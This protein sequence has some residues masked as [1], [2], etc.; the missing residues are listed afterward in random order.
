MGKPTLMLLSKKLAVR[1]AAAICESL[2][3]IESPVISL[4][5]ICL[6]LRFI[7]RVK[8]LNNCRPLRRARKYLPL[9]N[10]QKVAEILQNAA[11]GNVNLCGVACKIFIYKVNILFAQSNAAAFALR[12]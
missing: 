1:V 5:Y 3:F 2:F 4:F 6:Q 7:G 10:L 9:V 12:L 11:V 8:L